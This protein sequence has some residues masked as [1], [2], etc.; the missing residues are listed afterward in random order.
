MLGAYWG[1]GW[2]EALLLIIYLAGINVLL[3][4][5]TVRVFENKIIFQD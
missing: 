4:K 1:M 5:W 2:M 3:L